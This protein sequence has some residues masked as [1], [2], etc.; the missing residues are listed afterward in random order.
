MSKI[1]A[2]ARYEAFQE[3]YKWASHNYASMKVKK[4]KPIAPTYTSY[5]GNGN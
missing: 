5:G 2:K 1:S 3:W 4:Q